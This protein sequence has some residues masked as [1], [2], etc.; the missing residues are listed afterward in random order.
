ML[1][2]WTCSSLSMAQDTPEISSPVTD[3]A[4]VISA[5][6]ERRL[7]DDLRAHFDQTGVQMA[8]L[9]V[10]TTND[11]PI[12]DFSFRV[13]NE[14]GGGQAGED[15]G[16]LLTLA[17]DDRRSRLEVGYGLEGVYPDIRA[18]RTLQQ[19]RPRLRARSYD[20]AV[21]SVVAEVLQATDHLEPGARVGL[22]DI[23]PLWNGALGM[24][25]ITLFGLLMVG[26]PAVAGV[27]EWVSWSQTLT[28]IVTLLLFL[29]GAAL[30]FWM[31]QG[32]APWGYVAMFIAGAFGGL[33]MAGADGLHRVA[34]IPAFFLILC[35]VAAVPS[36]NGGMP[37]D[38]DG[39]M[40]F[41]AIFYAAGAV[42]PHSSTWD[43]STGA[44]RRDDDGGFSSGSSSSGAGGG[45]SGGGGSFGGGGASGGW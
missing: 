18:A 25:L 1:W 24:I 19:I 5:S 20:A 7:G 15:R 17:I 33:V 26:V 41:F 37:P 32:I 36:F 45:Y 29:V 38:A 4:D 16:I 8:V 13:A 39:K 31:A 28:I 21:T 27:E 42:I 30:T 23:H 11:E 35:F 22:L 34:P 10:P 43:T 6:V 44:R 12:E 2:V 3:R 9:T 14:W 40:L